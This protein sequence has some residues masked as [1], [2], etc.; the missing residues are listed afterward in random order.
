MRQRVA[1]S[2]PPDGTNLPRS[3]PRAH[4]RKGLEMELFILGLAVGGVAGARGKG[5]MKAAAKGYLT[6][7]DKAREITANVRED[8]RDAIAEAQ[9]ERETEAAM[10]EEMALRDHTGEED[11]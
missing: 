4:N 9:Y 6:L 10:R 1:Y 11:D 3:L 2:R 8:L 7:A 5:F